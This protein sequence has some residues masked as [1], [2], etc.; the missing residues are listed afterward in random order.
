MQTYQIKNHKMTLTVAEHGAEIRSVEVDGMERMWD[1]NPAF[2]GRTAPILFPIVGA[3]KDNS[4]QYEGE[5]YSMSQHGFA[6][7]M[8]FTLTEQT[9][10]S[11]QFV[12]SDNSE[13][14]E[15]YPF[16]FQLT[17]SY[18][19]FES[20][21]NIGW[22]VLNTDEKKMYFQIGGHPAF[23]CPCEG[24]MIRDD[25]SIKVG[26]LPLLETAFLEKGLLGEEKE[27]L[28][29]ELLLKEDTFARDAYIIQ[30]ETVGH[31]D[32]VNH[33]S[34]QVKVRVLADVPVWGIW[35][36]ADK[37]A[38]FVCI[39]PW[40]GRCDKTDFSGELSEREYIQ[41]L[42]PGETF[43]GGYQIEFM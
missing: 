39:E 6:R 21:I 33:V 19:I 25:Y 10:E 20:Y 41:S 26:E 1:A 37:K 4:Y 3:L 14:Y 22:K 24:G 16:H 42:E 11:L 29:N 12:L 2:W 8:E 18:E 13:T 28:A 35:S 38:P 7:D 36:T 15:N 43:T 30:N 32:L 27:L 9:E 34:N 17:V 23:A 31:V 5:T 40:Y